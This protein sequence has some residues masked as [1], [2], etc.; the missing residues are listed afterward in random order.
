MS[1]AGK[2]PLNIPSGVTIEKSNEALTIRGP[3]GVM[4]LGLTHKNSGL[5]SI[6]VSAQEVKVVPQNEEDQ[7]SRAMWG[8]TAR[9]I[10]SAI[11]GVV[12]GFSKKMGMKGVGYR[13]TV[14]GNKLSLVVGYSHD[15]IIDIPEGL[16]VEINAPT[17]FTISGIDKQKVGQFADK[18]RKIR[19]PEPYK[20]KGIFYAD[21]VIRRKEGKKK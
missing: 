8:T 10:K 16:S 19:L 21:E 14:S 11:D 20:G 12:S 6:E 15:V 9:L 4:T 7:A 17:E 3:K 2:H 13:A 1:R 5:V 18:V